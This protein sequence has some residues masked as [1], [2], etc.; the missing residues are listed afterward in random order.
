[1]NLN[2]LLTTRPDTRATMRS[3]RTS[4]DRPDERRDRRYPLPP[5]TVM[6]PAGEFVTVNWSLG[7]LLLAGYPGRIDLGTVLSGSIRVSDAFEPFPFTAK[8]VRRGPASGHVA[9]QF[10]D[11]SARGVDLLDRA[12]ARRLVPRR[13]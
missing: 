6:L 7:G 10:T 4:F 5:I 8:V 3:V 9:L 2:L 11:L 12:I 1:M 13:R